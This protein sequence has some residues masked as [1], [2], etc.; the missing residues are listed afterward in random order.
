MFEGTE[1][2]KLATLRPGARTSYCYYLPPHY[3]FA[4]VILPT[5]GI[6]DLDLSNRSM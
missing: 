3:P 5:T 2:T 1:L 4:I 6:G